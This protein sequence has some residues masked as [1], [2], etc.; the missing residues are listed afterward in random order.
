MGYRNYS[1]ANGF[2][3]D[4]LGNGDFTT[5]QAAITAAVSPQTIIIR[6]GTYTENPTL[7][8]GVNLSA[9]NCDALTPTVVINGNC[10][11]SAA[12]T[13]SIS[14]IELQTNSAPFLTVSGS[15][16]S[17]VNLNNCYFNCLNATGVSYSSSSAS[18]SIMCMQGEGN[19]ATTGIAVFASSSAGS[20]S[21]EYSTITNTGNSTTANTVSAGRC[22]IFFS[23]FKN[24]FTSS[25]TGGLA[26]ELSDVSTFAQNVTALTFNGSGSQNCVLSRI[27]GGTASVISIGGTAAIL[28]CVLDSS[29]ANAIAGAGTISYQGLAFTNASQTI[30]ATLTQTGG[31]LKGSTV[32]APSAGFIGERIASTGS[33]ASF[34]NNSAANFTSISLTPGIWDISTLGAISTSGSS[35]AYLVGIS[36]TSATVTGTLGDNYSQINQTNA[37]AVTITLATPSFRVAPTATTTYF[38]VGLAIFATGGAS[39][40]ARISAVRV[41]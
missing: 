24:P 27:L 14:G 20:I 23:A 25:G 12:G 33:V 6:P 28:S 5:I 3:V 35:S 21:F 10:T 15:A 16:A 29:N 37:G 9:W 13:V 38:A 22:N 30:A 32:Q 17:V 7:K 18:S 4:K 31:I 41:G 2:T 34:S 39:G 26:V 8:A 19:I 1:V 40:F 11:F 36:T